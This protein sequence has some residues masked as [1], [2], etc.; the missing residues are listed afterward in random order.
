MV[1]KT[2]E[3]SMMEVL[4]EE[5]LRQIALHQ[6][7][8]EQR[9]N[10]ELAEVQRLESAAK[11]K[12]AEKERR[13]AEEVSATI[14]RAELSEKVAARSFARNYLGTLHRQV[15]DTLMTSGH[16]YDPVHR[17]I[18]TFVLP[19]ILHEAANETGQVGQAQALVDQILLEML[20]RP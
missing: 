13:K 15:F 6:A 8:F 19:E 11:R 1:G 5:E 18:E 16:F 10:A 17:E 4:E 20:Q 2:L 7:D 14:A 9:R 12:A 3:R